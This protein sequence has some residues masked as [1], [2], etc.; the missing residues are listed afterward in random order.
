MP[1]RTF[2]NWYRRDDFIAYAFN[3][4]LVTGHPCQKPFPFL[5]EGTS[6]HSRRNNIVNSHRKKKIVPVITRYDCGII[7][8]WDLLNYLSKMQN[9]KSVPNEIS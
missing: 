9:L 1:S 4:R 6:A 5:H 2:L 8:E 3:T 7:R